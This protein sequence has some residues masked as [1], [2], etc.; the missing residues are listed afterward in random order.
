[1]TYEV[2]KSEEQWRDELSPEEYAVLR[3][4][5]T[6]R[7]WTGELLDEKRVG[8]YRCRACGNELFRSETKFDSH[9]GWPSFYS[10]LAGDRVELLEDRSLG[11]VRTEVRCARCGS[12][13]GH[14]FDDA[15][16]TPTGDRFCMNSIS[17]TF[18][19]G[20]A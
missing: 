2:S 10:P 12:H 5:G 14:V 18:E 15:P 13:L 4:A 8:V 7:A 11:M 17:L 9:C 19:A 1:M 20:D 16:Q 6:E 3:R